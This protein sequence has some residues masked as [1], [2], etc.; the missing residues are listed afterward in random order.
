MTLRLTVDRCSWA[1][2]EPFA[3]S[4]GI[5]TEQ[6]TVVVTLVD[7]AGC[8]GRGEACG[9]D[10]HGETQDSMVADVE[11]CRA[12]IEAGVS[13]EALQSLLPAGG[14]RNAVDCA[15]WDLVAKQRGRSLFAGMRFP[16]TTA[17]TIGIRE[18]GAYEATSRRY[19]AYPVLKIKVDDSDPIAAIEAVQRGAPAAK[20]IV[21]PNQAWTPEQLKSLAPRLVGRNVVLLEQP[22]PVG[23]ECSLDGWSSPIPICAD[24]LVNTCGDL[25]RVIGRFDVVNI[26]LDKAGGLT[27]ALRL[28]ELAREAG[29]QVMIGC[30]AGSSLAMAPGLIVAAH[31]TFVDLDGPLLHSRDVEHGLE[32]ADGRISRPSSQLWG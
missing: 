26:K 21:D 24:E 20:L 27:E 3:I 30:M 13:L 32:Y 23:A 10:Y 18:I 2:R 11:R 28:A 15:L 19:A 14:A 8:V 1:M 22:I 5:E 31:S 6:A 7:S 12:V 16:I 4:R 9:V 29:L 17:Y 25:D